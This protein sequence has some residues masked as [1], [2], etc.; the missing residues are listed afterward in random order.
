MKNKHPFLSRKVEISKEASGDVRS[1][2]SWLQHQ[3]HLPALTDEHILMFLHSCYFSLEQT[4]NT[5]DNYFT[6]RTQCKEMFTGWDF[7]KLKEQWKMYA[8][9]PIPKC[10]P[11][12]Y[13]V[14]IYRLTEL[15]PSTFAF[16]EAIKA[17]F[18]YNDIRISEDGIVNGYVVIFDMKGITLGHF[19]RISTCMNAIKKFMIYIQECHPVRLKSVH[20][21][22]TPPFI[23]I[24]MNVVKPLI[25]TEMMQLLNFHSGNLDTLS[26][27]VPL[28]LMPMDYGGKT[29]NTLDLHN[30]HVEM[31]EKRYK[32]WLKEIELFTADLK[33]RIGK[34]RNQMLAME[35]EGSFRSL[36]ID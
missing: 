36:S 11:E 34:P 27:F 7:D 12:G 19:A 1:I 3:P 6:V 32:S 16:I 17:F 13:C 28:E 18:A 35:L 29:R 33:K 4:K 14:L 23:D 24:F 10:T 31:V 30:E 25:N 21:I 26:K 9:A 2:R 8:M 15:D 22:N 5:I 20:V